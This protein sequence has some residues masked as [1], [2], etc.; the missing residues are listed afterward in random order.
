[1]PV[2]LC[3]GD[4]GND[5]RET[6]KFCLVQKTCQIDRLNRFNRGRFGWV[7]GNWSGYAVSGQRGA[8]RRVSA[9]WTVPFVLPASGSAYSSAWIGIDGFRNS[10]LIQTGTGHDLIQG[11]PL[12]YAWWEILPAAE[13]VIPLPVHPGDRIRAA[14]VKR[15]GSNWLI[16]IRNMTR[17][18]IFR[19]LQRY[20]GP[21]TSAEWIVEA[22]QLGASITP[23]ARISSVAFRSCRVNGGSPKLA[24]SDAGIMVQ[25][26]RVVSVPSAPNKAGDAFIVRRRT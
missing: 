16:C 22:P 13:T 24:L 8:F 10:N 26:N 1:M 19:T 2:K 4:S 3:G 23:L 17:G 15:S 11:K 20:A 25:N 5:K 14:I 21:R 9:E 12:Y 7:S 18:W 6:D